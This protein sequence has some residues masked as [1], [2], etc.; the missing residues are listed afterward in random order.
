M[1]L[2]QGMGPAATGLVAGLGLTWLAAAALR[3]LV[4]RLDA[5]DPATFAGVALFLL[6][7]AAAACLAPAR[8]AARIDPAISLRAE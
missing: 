5:R 4:F 1:I 7:A 6:A 3:P 8:R 2:A